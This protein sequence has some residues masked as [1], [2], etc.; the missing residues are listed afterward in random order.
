MS[1]K[2]TE[3]LLHE[4][5]YS[6]S[7]TDTRST[8]F[9]AWLRSVNTAKPLTKL[10]ATADH[11]ST[12]GSSSSGA[13]VV[14]DSMNSEV[15]NQYFAQQE[16]K[17]IAVMTSVVDSLHAKA[18]L[19]HGSSS[20]SSMQLVTNIEHRRALYKLQRDLASTSQVSTSAT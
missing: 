20:S 10:T 1:M 12:T 5:D 14:D 18:G 13:A 2:Q 8:V 19:L 16:D 6:T 4:Q 7:T 17:A 11:K 15:F 9:T 3:R